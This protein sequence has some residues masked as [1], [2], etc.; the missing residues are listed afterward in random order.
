MA[1]RLQLRT[2]VGDRAT[3]PLTFADHT[4]RAWGPADARLR[5]SVLTIDTGTATLTAQEG[6]W[7]VFTTAGALVTY[8]RGPDG[9]D[10]L[11]VCAPAPRR[12]KTL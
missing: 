1:G 2:D 11:G 8:A 4:S 3:A 10:V 12:P 6:T 5:G 7:R 9:V